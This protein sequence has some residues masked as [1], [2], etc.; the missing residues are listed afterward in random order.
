MGGNVGIGTTTPN[1]S[2][3]VVGSV[4][5]G[6]SNNLA[7]GQSSIA[8]GS[9]NTTTGQW[10]V[11]M[12]Y[13]NTG[14]GNVDQYTT[15][16]GGFNTTGGGGSVA[17]GY[18]NT[19]TNGAIAIGNGAIATGGNSAVAIGGYETN[20]YT[21]ASSPNSLA[22]GQG[23]TASSA[24]S[25]AIGRRAISAN[26]GA[27]VFA[28]S[29]DA[30]FS[31]TANDQLIIRAQGGVGIGTASTTSPLTVAGS[32]EIKGGNN[33][34][35][36]LPTS[37]SDAL[38]GVVSVGRGSAGNATVNTSAVGASSIVLLTAQTAD[39]VAFVSA[40]TPGASFTISREASGVTGSTS[41]GW[42]LIN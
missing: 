33:A 4:E 8:M 34:K 28:D 18:H 23:S 21:T 15:A 31:S 1:V 29:Q 27:I 40:R 39:A 35:F 30:D 11:E 16:I 41:I 6:D 14:V 20:H 12:G 26:A 25:I 3:V 10:C 9:N 19:A 13:G 36:I 32:I 37:V 17:I 22:M 5:M 38:A 7:G 42:M 24:N 2:L